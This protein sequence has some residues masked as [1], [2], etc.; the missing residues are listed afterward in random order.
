VADRR[1][2][3]TG[4]ATR[5]DGALDHFADH[6]STIATAMLANLTARGIRRLLA[7]AA[8]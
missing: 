6:Y 8:E 5:A 7:K 1:H 2:R 3:V 4:L